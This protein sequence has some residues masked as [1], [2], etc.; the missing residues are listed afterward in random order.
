MA[1]PDLSQPLVYLTGL[2][3]QQLLADAIAQALRLQSAELQAQ[4]RLSSSEAA[5]YLGCTV[6]FLQKLH[7]RGLPYEKGR[8]NFYRQSDLDAYRASLRL[9]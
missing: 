8:P 3:L 5:A 6:G 2:D 7:Q 9:G 4:R 1:S